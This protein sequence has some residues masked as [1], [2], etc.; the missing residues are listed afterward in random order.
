MAD[1]ASFIRGLELPEAPVHPRGEAAPA[2]SFGT[3]SQALIINSQMAE[4]D[5]TV[6]QP[7]RPTISYGL[8]LGQL[9]ADKAIAD[10][11]D[12]WKWFTTYNSIM[13]KIGWLPR[14]GEVSEQVIS[15]RNAELHK[16]VIP[17]L[18]A[19]LGSAAA[20]SNIVEVLKGLESMDQDAP[21]LTLFE[22]KSQSVNAAKF[23]LSY[24]DTREG[25]GA[26]LKT[27]FVGIEARHV[28]TAPS[29]WR[30]FAALART[31]R[32]E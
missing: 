31:D 8:L 24:V 4:F 11:R 17:I 14:A 32:G 7:M 9:A 19:A 5:S 23:G 15:D 25:G 2:P 13:G 1:V 10:I 6:P 21:W 22:R 18:T 12:P 28:L 16:A 27:V 3:D 26:S 20:G 29:T 30:A